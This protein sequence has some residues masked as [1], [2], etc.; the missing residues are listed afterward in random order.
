MTTLPNIPSPSSPIEISWLHA[1]DDAIAESRRTKRPILVDVYQDNCFGCDK[2]VDV[3]FADPRVAEAIVNRFVPVKLHLM[4]DRAITREWQVFWTPTV[5]FGDRSGKIRYTSP[6]FLPPDD[7]LDL[8]DIGEAL[9]AMRWQGYNDAITLLEGLERRSP[10]GP[11]TAEAA[12]WR[13]IA[14]YFK[15]G[16]SSRA[17]HAVW[18]V[19]LLPR[20]PESI[21]A[22]RI[23]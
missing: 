19:D 14:A 13:G 10:E 7:F 9:V 20:F 11:L 18:D 8:L 1:W 2:L 3:T 5:L 16:K 6:N 23:P 4:N 21:W 15:A 17:A 12:Y 22:K